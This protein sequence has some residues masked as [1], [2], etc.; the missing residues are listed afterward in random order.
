M[1]V[2]IDPY[3]QL[4]DEFN[5]QDDPWLAFNWK[6]RAKSY[7][8]P[9]EER[10]FKKEFGCLAKYECQRPIC[11]FRWETTPGPHDC[12]KCDSMWSTWLNSHKL[13]KAIHKKRNA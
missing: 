8:T 9:E 11:K 3:A 5:A 13:L 10:S 1:V 2:R 4:Q 7:G 6:F 12:P